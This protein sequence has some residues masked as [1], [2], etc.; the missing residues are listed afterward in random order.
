MPYASESA[1][2]PYYSQYP[3]DRRADWR[4][5]DK[6]LNEV[7]QRPD[8]KI[9]PLLR[10]KVLT[11]PAQATPPNSTT[12]TPAGPLLHPV[13]LAPASAALAAGNVSET[14]ARIFLGTDASGA[15]YFAAAVPSTDAA[16]KLA[17]QHP[18]SE[19]RSARL[20]GPDLAPG[21]ASLLGV[22]S[23]LMVWHSSNTHSASTGAPTVPRAGGFSRGCTAGG[24]SSYPRTDPA[25]I[26]QVTHAGCFTLLGRKPE[27]PQDRYSLLAG[28]LEFGEPLE[29]AV[30]REVEEESDVK[31][32][33]SSVTYH[34]SQPW[35]FPR[36]LM[37]GFSAST[38][39]LTHTQLKERHEAQQ[40]RR[41]A[42]AA[43]AAATAAAASTS[44]PDTA[45]ANGNGNGSNTSSTDTVP[46]S[47]S[48]SGVASSGST[49]GGYVPGPPPRQWWQ[50]AAVGAAGFDLL[51]LAGRRAALD[52]GLFAEEVEGVLR[53]LQGLQWPMAEEDEM[54]DVRW[55]HVD[56]LR[57]VLRSPV[58]PSGVPGAGK[59]NIPGPY[60]LANRIITGWA[61]AGGNAPAN[62]H[63]QQGQSGRQAWSG[64][65][66]PQVVISN[67][68]TFKYTLMRLWDPAAEG[69]A[70]GGMSK[71]KLL[72][73][74]DTRASYHMDVLQ[75]AK[76]LAVQYGLKVTPLGGGR[77][78]HDPERRTIEVYGYSAAFG[79][80]PHE[81][82]A[83][84]LHRWYPLYDKESITVSYEGY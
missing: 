39:P 41:E 68:G 75:K 74:G 84:M 64:E 73:W 1:D 70:D 65:G 69:E 59:F 30:V 77:I 58:G 47:S 20:A 51:P 9:I 3:L 10:D 13:L 6:L 37:I 11:M 4:R 79:P 48:T 46:T 42:H 16:A 21:D 61:E 44:G 17:E 82:S 55:F 66:F 83:A 15:P 76:A 12:H 23:G 5:N 31:V 26:M 56:W 14:P 54:Q 67:S 24:G 72:V 53:P 81:V 32:S 2:L 50:P 80:A 22:A 27:W 25:V 36:S 57:A 29:A 45:P 49:G 35:P 63:Q 40:R 7:F 71:S 60:A 18:G 28:F 8:A 43:A 19:W 34:S 38:A 78:R 52:V 62:P 33:L